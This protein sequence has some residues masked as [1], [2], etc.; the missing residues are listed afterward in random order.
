LEQQ[1]C[2]AHWRKAM[3]RRLKKLPGYPTEKHL[4]KTAL[5]QLEETGRHSL[6]WLPDQFRRAQERNSWLP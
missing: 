1:L 5:Q 3:A 4:L 2:L 6:H